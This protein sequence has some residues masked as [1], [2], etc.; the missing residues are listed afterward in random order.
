LATTDKTPA[1]VIVVV[2]M[3]VV[4]VP[5]QPPGNAQANDVAEGMAATENEATVEPEQTTEGPEMGPGEVGIITAVLVVTGV[6]LTAVLVVENPTPAITFV[7]YP[8]A[9][10][11]SSIP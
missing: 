1:A 11:T 7:V 5:V 2:M 9:P 10:A 6:Y 8:D 3:L 4:L